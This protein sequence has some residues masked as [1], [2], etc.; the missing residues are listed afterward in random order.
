[1]GA[2]DVLIAAEQLPRSDGVFGTNLEVG[3]VGDSGRYPS[4]SEG[5]ASGVEPRNLRGSQDVRGN[6]VES[7]AAK[8]VH[9]QA[10]I[11]EAD[12]ALEDVAGAAIAAISDLGFRSEA[13][14][15]DVDPI[16]ERV[17][18]DTV[19]GIAATAVGTLEGDHRPGVRTG[20]RIIV[21]DQV[22]AQ[23]AL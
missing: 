14:R 19:L 1:V 7:F 6:A 5:H 21:D 11:V 17:V 12:I 13:K 2:V 3:V 4:L 15:T 18:Q 23:R 8:E 9:R 16:F 20:Q 10:H 22:R